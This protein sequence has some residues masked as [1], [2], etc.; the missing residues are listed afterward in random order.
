MNSILGL[1]APNSGFTTADYR[2]VD[3]MG[4][5]SVKLL[6]TAGT[7]HT[8]SDLL[9][10]RARGVQDFTVRLRDTREPDGRYVGAQ[11]YVERVVPAARMFYALGVRRLQIDN[12]PNVPGMWDREGFGPWQYQFFMR[13]VVHLLRA[14]LPSDVVL[15]SPPLSYS[16]GLWRL[17]GANP[18]PFVLDDWLAAYHWTDGGRQ[19]SLWRCFDEVGANV[20]WQSERQMRDT[21]YGL[22]YEQLSA[23]AGGMPVT[24]LE[25]GNSAEG[26]N[27]DEARRVQYPEWLSEARESGLVR[28][29]YVFISPGATDDWAGFRLTWEQAAAMSEADLRGQSRALGGRRGIV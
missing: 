3:L 19:P 2:A 12:E 6:Y 21:S 17:G 20:Y 22:A 5:P 24:V 27:R 11:E 10:L 23:R 15:V 16:P 14:A 13:Y 18:T 1:H 8:P 9:T 4:A 7:R 26:I 29:A 25:F 28:R